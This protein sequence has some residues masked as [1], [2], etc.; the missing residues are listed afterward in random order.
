[1]SRF[2]DPENFAVDHRLSFSLS[3]DGNKILIWGDEKGLC[4]LIDEIARVLSGRDHRHLFSEEHA[5]WDLTPQKFDS[6]EQ[7]V[8]SV[9]ITYHENWDD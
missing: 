1:M 5:G 3:S 9:C 2:S 4:Y 8:H 6:D 7:P